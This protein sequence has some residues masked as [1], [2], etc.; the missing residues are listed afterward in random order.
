MN[1]FKPFS[2]IVLCLCAVSVARSLHAGG[3]DLP[4]NIDS[5]LRQVV[6]EQTTGKATPSAAATAGPKQSQLRIVA[7]AMRDAQNRV[8]VNVRLNGAAS[9]A[10]VHAQLVNGGASI[11][12]ETEQYRNGALS[13][14][15]PA[16]KVA[17]FAGLPGV[18]SISLAPRLHP[19]AGAA[20]SGGVFV[21]HT[22][23]LNAQGI[24]GNGVTVGVLSD[25][26]NTATKQE[27]GDPLAIHAEQDIATDDL[28][29]TGNPNGHTD[30][31][32]VV[33]DYVGTPDLPAFDEGR[34]MLQIVH[35]VAPNAKLAFATA[36]PTDIVFANNI[37][38][39]RTEANCDVIVDDII[40]PADPFFSDGIL[41]Q[42]VNDVAF[43]DS[44]PGHKVLYFS[45]AGNQQGGGYVTTFNPVPDN[46]ARAGLPGENVNLAAV[47]P[48]L[49]SGGFHNFNPD[50]NG[51]TV[52]AQPFDIFAGATVEVDLQWNDPFDKP[53]GVTTD[54]N[55]LVFDAN[56]NFL[57]QYSGT[58]DNFA[59]EEPIEDITV[60]NPSGQD[61]QFQIVISRKGTTPSSPVATKLRYLAVG[62][63]GSGVPARKFYQ[64]GAPCTFG[65]SCAVGA[66]GVSAYAYDSD[67]SNPVAP[68]FTPVLEDTSSPGPATY[69]FD[70]AGNRLAQPETRQ[71]PDIA[72]PDGGNTTFF[73]DF[74]YE[75]D[76]LLNFF[77]T[78]AAAPHAAG[79]AAL[80]LQKAGGSG[81]LSLNEVRS[82]LQ[83][84]VLEPHDLD[85]FVSQGTALAQRIKVKG[86][87][88]KRGRGAG[89]SS[90]TMTV[91]AHG[92]SSDGS[93]V[94][95][96]FF[97]VTFHPAQVGETL[98]QVTI[99]LTNA[100][101][102]F[103]STT[104]FGFPVAL[105]TLAGIGP[106][107]I[108]VVAPAETEIFETLTLDFA[109]GAFTGSASV[110]VGVDRDVVG[111]GGGNSADLLQS[112]VIFGL[113]SHGTVLRGTLTN[114]LGFGYSLA[115]GFGLIDGQK[116][117]HQ[118]P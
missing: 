22:D 21:L 10:Q 18:L 84:S 55:V 39:L 75:G 67:P 71:K 102:S 105:G 54:Y 49:T 50:P 48:S 97:T 16:A 59:T 92:D 41:G 14:Y 43:S 63:F 1:P 72:G 113:T 117:V 82:A 37:R 34:A 5:A 104:D 42:A 61:T 26:Y 73:G 76:G 100:G 6:T 15:V 11:V 33:E 20:T 19:N 114:N 30:P 31:V 57:A 112:A 66:I 29:G 53:N 9:L 38:R 109:R 69:Y 87:R 103:D 3:I 23:L 45:A 24:N 78:S 91:T 90:A 83:S 107:D 94:D 28:P 77:G 95:P 8:L 81:A 12:A 64:E 79:V 68:P 101:E 86:K 65:H 115:D 60:A 111:S 110:S 99:N 80:L 4:A 74:D 98:R 36:N 88:S 108:A 62:N 118:L 106:Q 96:N 93:A 17:E 51:P 27:S 7:P 116:A 32:D 85:P 2:A 13:A 35:D 89:H 40:S 58:A 25:S 46:V 52:I 47:N 70:A 56:G 44:L